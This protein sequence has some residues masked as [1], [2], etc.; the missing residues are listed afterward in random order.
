[1]QGLGAILA[2]TV[3]YHLALPCMVMVSNPP[4]GNLWSYCIFLYKHPVGNAFFK[5]WGPV[6]QILS[7]PMAVGKNGHLQTLSKLPA[8]IRAGDLKILEP[9]LKSKEIVN[10]YLVFFAYFNASVI[11]TAMF[12]FDFLYFP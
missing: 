3:F 6:L 10:F 8:C 2:G 5:R 1:M 12:C 11:K 9:N 4:Y 7:S